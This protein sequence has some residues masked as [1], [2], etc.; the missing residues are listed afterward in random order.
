MPKYLDYNVTCDLCNSDV[1][2]WSMYT[3]KVKY[4]NP[5]IHAA[6]L[7]NKAECLTLTLSPYTHPDLPYIYV[8]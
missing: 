7:I 3:L 1:R 2:S 5:F 8:G 6:S 4:L